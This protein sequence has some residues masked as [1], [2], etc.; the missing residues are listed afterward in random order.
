MTDTIE[1]L[2]ERL[3]ENSASIDLMQEQTRDRNQ[4]IAICQ[5]EVSD[6]K[7]RLAEYHEE[8]GEL[9][10][11]ISD[12][13]SQIQAWEARFVRMVEERDAAV[14]QK[15]IAARLLAKDRERFNNHKA[16]AHVLVASLQDDVTAL[17]AERDGLWEACSN[18]LLTAEAMARLIQ[19]EP[20]G[21]LLPLWTSDIANAKTAIARP[22]Q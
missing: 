22:K 12:R 7:R 6:L 11:V 5:A 10:H 13:Q 1:R 19:M 3:A 20:E 8:R 15:D 2:R 14:R 4:A 17:T 9:M 16:R 18:L 21:D